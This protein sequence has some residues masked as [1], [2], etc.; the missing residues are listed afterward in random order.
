[1]LKFKKTRPPQNKSDKTK[2]P[3]NKSD[4]EVKVETKHKETVES[5]DGKTIDKKET[6]DKKGTNNGK[7]E[8]SVQD[9]DVVG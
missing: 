9:E 6:F 2:V 7:Q 3:Q 8:V 4:P 1:M 5:F